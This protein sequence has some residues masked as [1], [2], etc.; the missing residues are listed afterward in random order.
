MT[1]LMP[2]KNLTIKKLNLKSSP[3]NISEIGIKT[4]INFNARM[5]LY[6]CPFISLIVIIK[7][8]S[9]FG[10]IKTKNI[11]NI[12]IIFHGHLKKQKEIYFIYGP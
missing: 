8:W 12:S 2:F 10:T 9:G 11:I 1:I 5:T 7:Y 6:S 3:L 4:Q